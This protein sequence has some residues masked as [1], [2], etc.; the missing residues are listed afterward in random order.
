MQAPSSERNAIDRRAIRRMVFVLFVLQ[1][2]FLLLLGKLYQVQV[3][4]GTAGQDAGDYERLSRGAPN[5]KRGKILDR[6]GTILGLSRHRLHVT[7]DPRYM[8]AD[9][10]EVARQLAPILGATEAELLAQ[11]TRKN[12]RFVSL[13]RD[14]DYEALDE[15][16]ALQ[17]KIRGLKYT[18]EQGRTYPKGSLAAQVIGNVNAENR[19]EGI[20]YQYNAYLTKA[21]S[22]ESLP[23]S[24]HLANDKKSR[25][26]QRLFRVTQEVTTRSYHLSERN[27]IDRKLQNAA[28]H[29]GHSVVLTIDEY[30]QYVAEKELAAACKQWHAPRGT[31]IVLAS[32]TAEIL[33]LASYPTYELNAYG[34]ASEE[35]KRN[36]G[37][38]F[39][40]EPGSVFKIVA[41][42]AALNQGI[43]TRETPI[44]CEHGRFRVG[45]G[46]VVRDVSPKGW[47]TLEEILHK[48][49]NIG[50][51]KIVQALGHQHFSDY[52]GK[53]G[54]GRATGIDLPHEHSGSLYA[55]RN[56]DTNSLGAVPFGQGILVTPLQMVS[57]LNVIATGGEL[58]R[59]YITREI[60]D[61]TGKVVKKVY[62]IPV[63]RVL[64]PAVA[65]LMA[66]ILVGVVEGGSGRRAQV[67]GY[68]VAGKTGTAQKAEIGKGY[69]NGKEIMSFMGF[70]PAE[71]PQV[72]IIV[73]L[74]EP[75][76]ARFSGQI[77][78]PLFKAVATQTMQ[79]FKQTEF[80][81]SVNRMRTDR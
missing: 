47:L 15:I 22:R 75:T 64:K 74:D 78:A 10:R 40:Y 24:I 56:W 16:R 9:P 33:A 37:V 3:V 70:L 25:K 54:F 13:K 55:V 60:R 17:K 35:A 62:P 69:V 34:T 30:I 5:V 11:L 59:P 68:R 73:M 57:A 67:E 23:P 46:R 14:V 53:Y 1:A 48:S 32:K 8:R 61:S 2:G 12:K 72:S 42:S 31:V 36:M 7:A 29:Y 26:R 27:A 81:S 43:M 80:F 77:A 20:E 71:N 63:R 79:Y 76:G 28:A 18:V 49:N 50:M 52:I 41:S 44:F 66:E 51:I 21:V 65:K 58:M 45:R 19:G 38:W 6:H 39:A 4:N